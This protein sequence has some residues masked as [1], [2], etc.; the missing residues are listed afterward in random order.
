MLKLYQ[1][2]KL[3]TENLYLEFITLDYKN[4]LLTCW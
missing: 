4:Q 3:M 1:L 2:S